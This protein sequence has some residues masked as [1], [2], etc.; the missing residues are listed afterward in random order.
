[1]TPA[2]LP[3]DLPHRAA[4]GREDFLIADANRSAV[5]FVDQWPAWPT[6]TAVLVGPAGAGKTHLGH[7][8]CALSRARVAKATDLAPANVPDLAEGKA[9]FLEDI[10]QLNKTGEQALF[11]LINLMKEV[12]GHL[13]MSSRSAPAH[14]D[15]TLPDLASRLRAAFIVEMGAPD[16]MLLAAVLQKLFNDRQLMATDAVLAYLTAHMDRSVEA[17]QTLVAEIDRASLAGK[18]RITVPFV[19]EILRRD[20]SPS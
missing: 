14:L 20:T 18:R 11:H 1:M 12:G 5:A 13:L 4:L 6:H 16:D 9:V 10:D 15:L 2:Q 7:V 3:L 17:A 19:A 8:W